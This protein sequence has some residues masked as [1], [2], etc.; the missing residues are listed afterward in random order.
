MRRRTA[1]WPLAPFPLPPPSFQELF[2]RVH[3]AGSVER[4][5]YLGC[6][7]NANR[8]KRY[9]GHLQFDVRWRGWKSMVGVRALLYVYSGGNS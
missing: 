1:I 2:L 4:V 3:L 5:Q 9:D 7:P 8:M 6:E